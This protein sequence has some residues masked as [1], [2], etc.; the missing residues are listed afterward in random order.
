MYKLA[1]VLDVNLF[2]LCTSNTFFFVSGSTEGTEALSI[3]KSFMVDRKNS[4][5]GVSSNMPSPSL[6]FLP[7]RPS[8]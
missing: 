2:A 7:V 4:S 8:R 1:E 5:Q 3:G 6:P